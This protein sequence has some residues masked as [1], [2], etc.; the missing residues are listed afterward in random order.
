MLPL[1]TR[2]GG[3]TALIWTGLVALLAVFTMLFA[4]VIPL[5]ESV[6]A[7]VSWDPLS[8]DSLITQMTGLQYAW[9][10]FPSV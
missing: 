2:S 3:G 6:Q 1:L 5:A 7:A 10:R 9:N 8:R 4:P